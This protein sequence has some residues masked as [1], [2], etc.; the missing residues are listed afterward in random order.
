MLFLNDWVSAEGGFA[1][2]LHGAV[3]ADVVVSQGCSP[4][5][6]A[7]EVTGAAENLILTLDGQ[8]ALERAEQVLR[9]IVDSVPVPV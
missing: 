6:P 2:A 7:L 5:G 4:I 8:P 1:I 3:R 9:E